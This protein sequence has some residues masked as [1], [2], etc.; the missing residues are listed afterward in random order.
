M[1]SAGPTLHIMVFI[2]FEHQSFWA[3]HNLDWQP[4]DQI[5][6]HCYEV[7]NNKDGLVHDKTSNLSVCVPPW[8]KFPRDIVAHSSSE[9]LWLLQFSFMTQSDGIIWCLHVKGLQQNLPVFP[10]SAPAQWFAE[11]THCNSRLLLETLFVSW[12]SPA[13][14]WPP[15]ISQQPVFIWD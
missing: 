4:N 6:G 5:V 2:G 9:S 3:I 11:R 14:S 7:F 1:T 13:A 10:D 12:N 8:F 15:E